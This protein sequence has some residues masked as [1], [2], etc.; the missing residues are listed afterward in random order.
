M[1]EFDTLLPGFTSG[2]GKE[3]NESLRVSLD[4]PLRRLGEETRKLLP[5]LAVFQGRAKEDDLLE[6][7][8]FPPETWAKA[9]AELT[10][11]GL[12]TLEQLQN[13]QFPYINFHPTLLPYLS[14]QLDDATRRE[15]EERYRQRYHAVANH[16]YQTDDKNPVFA[17][18]IVVRELP[19]LRR[20]LDLTI[21][22]GDA[23][24]AA[25]LAECSG[26]KTFIN[27]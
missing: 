23:D 16:L 6:I 18:A 22:V 2:A 13:A 7:T 12:V 14:R 27:V 25:G 17:R 20:A 4:F 5:A 15:I 21:A 3:R 26:A 8:K 9:R 11:A 24:V 10:R 19:N 1:A